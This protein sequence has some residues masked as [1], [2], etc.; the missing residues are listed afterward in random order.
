MLQ[1]LW[2]LRP[3]AAI[4]I[5]LSGILYIL[6]VNRHL[7]MISVHK[8]MTW[9]CL[10]FDIGPYLKLGA[11]CAIFCA[12]RIIFGRMW[13]WPALAP[14]EAICHED[15]G[16]LSNILEGGGSRFETRPLPAGT[17]EPVSNHSLCL[18]RASKDSTWYQAYTETNFEP[19][20]RELCML[21]FIFHLPLY[22]SSHSTT[23]LISLT[24][25]IPVIA[26]LLFWEI[27]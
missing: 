5:K 15:G 11:L 2:L 23:D 18:A 10:S 22:W 14:G 12:P 7:W 13:P 8:F 24:P 20:R 1:A 3:A 6:G 27:G 19:Q 9:R 16:P 25:H 21:R 4:T 17:A 26:F